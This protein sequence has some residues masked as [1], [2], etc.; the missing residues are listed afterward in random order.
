MLKLK[1]QKVV[2]KSADATKVKSDLDQLLNEK[3]AEQRYQKPIGA[4][5]TFQTLEGFQNGLREDHINNL[6]KQSIN[7][8]Q[9]LDFLG[10]ELKVSRCNSPHSIMWE[11]RS[12]SKRFRFKR[13]LAFV[14]TLTAYLVFCTF[15]IL[16]VKFML[17]QIKF[18]YYFGPTC[19]EISAMF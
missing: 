10:N 16:I 6:V 5:I 8:E 1:S 11:N 14:L 4:F 3:L 13:G 19:P 9:S 2:D 18:H 15:C 12:N 7:S 17:A